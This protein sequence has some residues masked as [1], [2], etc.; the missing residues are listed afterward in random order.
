MRT[1]IRVNDELYRQIKAK[2]A[3][4]GRPVAALIEDAIRSSLVAGRKGVPQ[5]ISP[6]PTFGKGGTMPGVD[7]DDTAALL[8]HMEEGE[9]L[10]ARR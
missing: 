5:R 9:A 4:T 3:R 7:L 1:T 2:A 6:L 10:R 8:G